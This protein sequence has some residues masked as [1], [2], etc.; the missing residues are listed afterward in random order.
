M[1]I[2]LNFLKR[3]IYLHLLMLFLIAYSVSELHSVGT[4]FINSFF[5]NFNLNYAAIRL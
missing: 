3:Y 1:C 4:C 5:H 2:L